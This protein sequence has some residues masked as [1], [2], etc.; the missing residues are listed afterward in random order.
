MKT[1]NKIKGYLREQFNI[2]AQARELGV[3]VWQAPSVLFVFLGIVIMGLMYLVYTSSRIQDDVL[4][5][6]M[7]ETFVVIATLLVGGVVIRSIE[8]IARANKMKSE[9]IS[10]ASH[11]MKGPLAQI[12]WVLGSM[13][14]SSI[15]EKDRCQKSFNIIQNSNDAMIE[16]VN[17]LLDI[18]RLERGENIVRLEEVDIARTVEDI[19]GHYKEEGKK[20]NVIL[21]HDDSPEEKITA[22]ADERRF[23]VAI[24]NLIRNAIAYTP[25]GGRVQV[26]VENENEKSVRI[27][28]K[29]NGI[30]IPESEQPYLF[31]RFFR[32]SNAKKKTSQGTGLG[33]YLT[34]SIV[35]QSRGKIWFRSIEGSGSMFC[36]VLPKRCHS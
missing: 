19:I 17:D 2:V 9:F 36:I 11:Q 22:C 34:R 35:E 23:R 27:C 14:F 10:I 20:Q 4:F 12:K 8:Q 5:L 26:S 33:L 13:D 28:V 29:D 21:I 7:A 16:L 1:Y 30:G 32:A 25:A 6:V 3:P 18:A 31:G 15:E 24:D